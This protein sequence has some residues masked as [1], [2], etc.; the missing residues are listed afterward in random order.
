MIAVK[1]LML[2]GVALAISAGVAPRADAQTGSAELPP[3]VTRFVSRSASCSEWSKNAI[4]PE[5]TAQIE[6]I[7]SNLE[8][9]KCF[10]ILDDA[11]A[12][13]EICRQS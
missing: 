4:D 8:S 1:R 10:D 2:A 5:W 7:Y 3:D 11:R 13:T 12:S 6:V 9:L